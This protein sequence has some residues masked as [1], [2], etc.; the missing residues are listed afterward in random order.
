MVY[1]AII[2][3]GVLVGV[4]ELFLLRSFVRLMLAG[5]AL[6]GAVLLP[7]KL[8]LLALGLLPAL[9]AAPALL[10]LS[11]LCIAGSLLLGAAVLGILSLRK[12]DDR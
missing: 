5:N 9:L 6:R 8:L 12:G 4:A 1:A 11:G 10:W 3:V 7:L 2:A